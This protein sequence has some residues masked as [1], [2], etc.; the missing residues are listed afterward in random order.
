MSFLEGMDVF[1]W[2]AWMSFWKARM[3]ESLFTQPDRWRVLHDT[4]H[5][6]L[7]QPYFCC[8]VRHLSVCKCRTTQN[9]LHICRTV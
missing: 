1:F 5:K 8:V 6:K 3:T 2:K 4:T 7:D 9:S